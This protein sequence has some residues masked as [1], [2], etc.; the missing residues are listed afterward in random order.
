MSEWFTIDQDWIIH[1]Y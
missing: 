1:I